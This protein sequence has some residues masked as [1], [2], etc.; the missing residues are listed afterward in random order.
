MS[1]AA[2]VIAVALLAALGGCKKKDPGPSIDVLIED[3]AHFRDEMCACKDKACADHVSDEMSRW[4]SDKAKLPSKAPHLGREQTERMAQIGM[5]YG[6]CFT[7][8]TSDGG[9]GATPSGSAAAPPPREP[10]AGSVTNADAL[11]KQLY[12]SLDREHVVQ[13]LDLAYIHADGT[14]DAKYGRV[15]AELGKPK[16][17]SPADDPNRPLGAP[18]P[19][20]HMTEDVL[21]QCPSYTWEGGKRSDGQ[22]S[23]LMM[24]S[25]PIERPKCSVVAI[26][27]QAI[28]AGAPAAALAQLSIHAGTWTLSI[29]DAPRN[30]HFQQDFPDTCAPTLEKP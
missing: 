17:P 19:D 1:K 22:T 3:M 12:D 11:I 10:P 13:R 27:K 23:C 26:W 28:D 7:A 20:D 8:A 5:E 4:A 16:R 18:V 21:A 29:D 2:A 15:T 25:E 24:L 14:I 6:K 30:V 9:A